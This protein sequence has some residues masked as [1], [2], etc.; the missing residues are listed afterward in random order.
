[1]SSLFGKTQTSSTSQTQ[2]TTPNY[3]DYSKYID[4]ALNKVN[5]WSSGK[6]N[7]YTGELTP[8][9]TDNQKYALNMAKSNLGNTY[10]NDVINGKYLDYHNDP[11]YTSAVGQ[12][13]NNMSAAID[14]T[15]TAFGRS[16]FLSSSGYGKSQQK[17][18]DDYGLS[19]GNLEGKFSDSAK[20]QIL[21]ALGVQNQNLSAFSNL[22][23]AE[24]TAN[25]DADE[26]QYKEFLRKEGVS[27][28]AI[29]YY[30]QLLSLVKGT[31]TTSEGNSSV[32]QSG[33]FG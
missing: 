11:S 29:P 24:Y 21:Q 23:N 7:S 27:E 25:K 31:T 17:N 32:H 8:G 30:A 26:A 3:G 6:V 22:A 9:F 19:L 18:V 20:N 33:L 10:I 5:D 14:S 16:G 13:K 15:K 2:T 1:M 28:Q 12:L 4:T